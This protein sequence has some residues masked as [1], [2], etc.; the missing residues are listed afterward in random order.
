MT[1]EDQDLKLK[2]S[3]YMKV[4]VGGSL[5]NFVHLSGCKL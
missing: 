4:K 3:C 1:K 5:I 2:I